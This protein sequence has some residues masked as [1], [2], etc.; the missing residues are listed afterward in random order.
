MPFSISN[1]NV[2][3]LN[4]VLRSLSNNV[5]G[6]SVDR[7]KYPGITS[8]ATITFNC[9]HDMVI[10]LAVTAT[11]R[12]VAAMSYGQ[13]DELLSSTETW[14]EVLTTA[15]IVELATSEG[16]FPYSCLDDDC[17]DYGT[18]CE[19]HSPETGI[20]AIVLAKSIPRFL[21]TN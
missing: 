6:V 5:I 9:E 16:Q 13:L 4:K 12:K 11:G 15:N 10:S 19:S 7:F 8:W 2:A 14:D 3:A 21:F 1:E 18:F 17:V 20:A